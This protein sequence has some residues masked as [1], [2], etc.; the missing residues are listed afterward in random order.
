MEA[1]EDELT[2]MAARRSRAIFQVV[3]PSV[4]DDQGDASEPD[5]DGCESNQTRG[6]QAD[7]RL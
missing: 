6:D 5:D 3:L 4:E 1:G 2:L 7:G